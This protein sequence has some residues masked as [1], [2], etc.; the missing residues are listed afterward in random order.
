[1]KL[2]LSVSAIALTL[3]FSAAHGQQEW[4]GQRFAPGVAPPRDLTKDIKDKDWMAWIYSYCR[5]HPTD[6]IVNAA[7][8]LAKTVSPK[9]P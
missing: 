8:E 4:N 1:M 6:N 3:T 5:S 2:L 7:L 9:T